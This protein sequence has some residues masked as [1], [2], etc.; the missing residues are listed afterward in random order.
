MDDEKLRLFRSHIVAAQRSF[1]SAAKNDE[2]TPL[3]ECIQQAE[4]ALGVLEADAGYSIPGPEFQKSLCLNILGKA[5]AAKYDFDGHHVSLLQGLDNLRE[6]AEIVSIF[7]SWSSF[8]SFQEDLMVALVRCGEQFGEIELLKEAVAISDIHLEQKEQVDPE[9]T[10]YLMRNTRSVAELRIGTTTGD[11]GLVEKVCRDLQSLLKNP[12][13]SPE[14]KE[15]TQR[16]VIA[17]L[18]ENAK[19][20]RNPRVYR[21]L[22]IVLV[23]LVKANNQNGRAFYLH[24]LATTRLELAEMT[25]DVALMKEAIL[26]LQQIIDLGIASDGLAFNALHTVAHAHSC[27]GKHEKSVKHFQ[28]AIDFSNEALKLIPMAGS[29]RDSRITRL[30]AD[31]ASFYFGLGLLSGDTQHYVESENDYLFSLRR[32]SAESAPWLFSRVS[33]GLFQLRFRQKRW[34]EALEAFAAMERGWRIST[35]EP[36]LS[37]EIHAQRALEMAKEYPLAAYCY[38]QKDQP[39]MAAAVVDRGRAQQLTVSWNMN[40]SD[41]LE[42][43]D[44]QAVEIAQAAKEWERTRRVGSEEECRQAWRNYSDLMHQG[45]PDSSSFSRSPD[46]VAHNAPDEG[47]LVFIF[48]SE[49]WLRGIVVQR[50]SNTFTCFDFTDIEK[51]NIN[52]VLWGDGQSGQPGWGSR[53][54]NFRACGN[55]WDIEKEQ[56]RFRCWTGVIEDGLEKLGGSLMG[57]IHE[58]L[59]GLGISKGSPV[60]ILPPG[61]LGALPMASAGLDGGIRFNEYW[62]ASIVPN[63]VLLGESTRRE[64]PRSGHRV[65]VISDWEESSSSSTLEDL[66]FSRREGRIV[67]SWLGS[68]SRVQLLREGFSVSSVIDAFNEASIVHVACHGHYDWK[69]PERSGLRLPNNSLLTLG[70]LKTTR[71]TKIRNRLVVLSCCESGISGQTLP[72]DEFVGILPSFLNCGAQAVIGSLWPVYDDAAMLFADRFYRFY[73]DSDGREKCYPSEALSRAQTWLKSVTFRELVKEGLISS[74][75]AAELVESRFGKTRLRMQ[76]GRFTGGG[77]SANLDEVT[78][79]LLRTKPYS[80]PVDWAAFIV[81]GY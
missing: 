15:F 18:A 62:S 9:E 32:L 27:V 10:E 42:L 78:D 66:P 28:A 7:P 13:L 33:E 57:R 4:A 75:E 60:V 20:H 80:S 30:F 53:Y 17:A 36:Y 69:K 40:S 51:G 72:P 22:I 71:R 38:L 5:Q 59:I 68:E 67:A 64:A 21:Q 34:D 52:K 77:H 31:R 3:L 26:D 19:Q 12:R 2:L 49:Q 1:F 76:E 50:N 24:Y 58:E 35:M 23:G 54:Q 29:D 81:V 79:K 74:E 55:D 70:Q 45:A 6:A 14:G 41:A 73:L 63:S 39:G 65:L 37:A 8:R 11:R 48:G 43:E 61:E 46:D 25:L 56:E 44:E 47:V 16:N